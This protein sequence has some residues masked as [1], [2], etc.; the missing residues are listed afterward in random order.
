VEGDQLAIWVESRELRRSPG[1]AF[2]LCIR[3]SDAF[4]SAAFVKGSNSPPLNSATGCLGDRL[5]IARR[6]MN[7]NLTLVDYPIEVLLDKD[8][9]EVFCLFEEAAY[10]FDV[11]RLQC[12]CSG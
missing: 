10:S 4:G 6:Q 2:Q 3:V 11:E 7:V 8:S 5:L 12:R 1:L 9:G